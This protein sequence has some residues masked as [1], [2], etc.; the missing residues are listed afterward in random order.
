MSCKPDESSW[1][2]NII[3]YMLWREEKRIL[4]TTMEGK[5]EPRLANVF[6]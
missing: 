6:M 5:R 1:V 3:E 4:G 2:I